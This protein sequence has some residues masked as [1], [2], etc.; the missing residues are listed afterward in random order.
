MKSP[1]VN[2]K[3]S[4][5]IGRRVVVLCLMMIALLPPLAAAPL[6]QSDF[7]SGTIADWKVRGTTEHLQ[8]VKGGHNS[9]SSLAITG[10]SATWQGAQHPIA[11]SVTAGGIYHISAWLKY[12]QGPA[13]RAFN[14]SVELGYSDAKMPHQYRNLVSVNF[15]RG[16]W[17]QFEAEFTAP[18]DPG[19]NQ[20]D[21][22]FESPWKADDQATV[23]DKL[24][25][26][27]DDISVSSV[28]ASERPSAQEDIPRLR[29][30]LAGTLIL[31]TAVSPEQL[32]KS[33][34]HFR[35]LTRHYSAIVA[36]N[37]MKPEALQPQEGNFQFAQADKLVQ[38][39]ALTGTVLRG[40]TLL[41]HNQTPAWFFTDPKNPVKP[42]SKALLMARLKN[43]IKTVVEHFKG[44]VYCWDVVNEVLSD[45]AGLRTG[46]EGSKWY[47]ILGK[48]YIDAAFR[49][50]HAADPDA[51][52][53]INDY[54]LE[55]DSRKRMEMYNLV[56]GMKARGVPVGA[57]GLQAHISIY[58]PSVDEFRKTIELFASLGVKVQVTELDLSIYSSPG[59]GQKTVTDELLLQQGRRYAELFQM[60]REEAKAGKLDMVMVWGSADD[61]TWLDNF[62]VAGR[63]DAP[64]L[65]DR[66]LQA[67]PAFW[68]IV[69]PS[70]LPIE[71]KAKPNQA[72][73]MRGTPQL[74]ASVDGLW[75]KA[76]IFETRVATMGDHA[77]SGKFRMLWDDKYLYV[78]AEVTDPILDDSSKNT[79]EQDSVEVF[80]D[81]NNHK[82]PSYEADDGQF[83]VNFKNLASYNGN[84]SA[85]T[86]RSEAKLIP[87]GYLVE[88][89]I[90]FNAIKP[91]AGMMVG[92]DAQINNAE[93]KGVRTG[94]RNFNDSTNSGWQ[95][96]AGYGE[97]ILE[98]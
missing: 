36:G 28:A 30:V 53:V 63:L 23:D 66:K 64:L 70:R 25:F 86:F 55:G 67:K 33:D 45:S 7:E 84:A 85:Q 96:T 20:V 34:P 97:L 48:D 40:H 56:K 42:A 52:L 1:R 10:R 24:D 35:L 58:G 49:F 69:D 11:A 54:N 65:F 16:T 83:R 59:E 8:L 77:A 98:N 68:G 3:S 95:S 46:A 21:I 79:Y 26:Q 81:Q 9:G 27:I 89:A 80:L 75:K 29:D 91:A 62:P 22:Y 43:H 15:T 60:F 39:A 13:T 32:D 19:L 73:A 87:G 18:N 2:L 6:W 31:G 5:D 93:G 44:D 88:M 74:D 51:L 71:T 14:L 38:Y 72:T 17:A 12:D 50:A 90:P 78:L 82:T 41:W 94:Q 61:D 37:A 57:V 4:P 92:F 76:K 47:E